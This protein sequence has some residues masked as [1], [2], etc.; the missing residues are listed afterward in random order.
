VDELNVRK[1]MLVVDAREPQDNDETTHR[2]K[3]GVSDRM[4]PAASTDFDGTGINDTCQSQVDKR[5]RGEFTEHK[6]HLRAAGGTF[7]RVIA[8]RAVFL[9]L[10]TL[11]ST[12]S[13][14]VLRRRS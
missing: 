3:H 11:K 10:Q 13:E 9:A 14:L 2:E 1:V 8:Q 6:G 5:D 4:T 12:R 7:I